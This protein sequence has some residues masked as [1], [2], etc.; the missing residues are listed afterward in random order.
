[1]TGERRENFSN[2]KS[3]IFA[4]GD[5]IRPGEFSIFRVVSEDVEVGDSQF[6][7][8]TVFEGTITDLTDNLF[9][10]TVLKDLATKGDIV[11]MYNPADEAEFT[12]YLGNIDDGEEDE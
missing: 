8:E 12:D 3:L 6:E 5:S 11:F 7:M 10:L 2:K 4:H 1:M 9:C